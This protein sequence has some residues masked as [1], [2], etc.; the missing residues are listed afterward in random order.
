MRLVDLGLKAGAMITIVKHP[1]AGKY[2][3]AS[4]ESDDSG[5]GYE[6]SSKTVIC[7]H[8]DSRVVVT[9]AS[10]SCSGMD[11][12]M[13]KFL[14]EWHGVWEEEEVHDSGRKLKITLS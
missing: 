13:T 4:C 5:S 11:C 14:G 8:E 10:S 2:N 9:H 7:L 1:V 6:A 3:V 12:Y